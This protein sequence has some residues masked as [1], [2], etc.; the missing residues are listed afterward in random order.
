MPQPE[1]TLDLARA[2]LAAQPFNDLVGAELEEFGGGS[3]TLRL[4]IEDRHRQQFGLVH[5]GVYAYLA[6]NAITFAAGSV[7]GPSVVTA[8]FTISYLAGAREGSL[9]AQARVAHHDRRQAACVVE[10]HVV[11]ADGTRR[12][13]SLAQ[14]TVQATRAPGDGAP[15]VADASARDFSE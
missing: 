4:P 10:I 2:V 14:G 6:D 13:C 7:L 3:A 8:G 15:A 9:I 1:L 12:L 5:G 11:A